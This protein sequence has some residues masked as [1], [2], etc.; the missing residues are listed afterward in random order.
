MDRSTTIEAIEAML[1]KL[2]DTL[3]DLTEAE[4]ADYLGHVLEF[5]LAS[6]QNDAQL[7][8][9]IA[10]LDRLLDQPELSR[11][12]R[13]YLDALTDLVEVYESRQVELP[14][15]SGVEI[16]HHLMEANDLQQKDL[17]PFFGSKSIVSEVLKGKRPLA[18]GH[19]VKLSEHFGLPVD[20]FVDRT[21][22]RDDSAAQEVPTGARGR[23]RR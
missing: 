5:P 14:P 15:V 4:R 7:D 8:D 19:I 6:I 3:G 23:L 17:I 10:K 1:A 11:G 12:G 18:L 22:A 21:P 2:A 16:L 9:A 13:L 20:V